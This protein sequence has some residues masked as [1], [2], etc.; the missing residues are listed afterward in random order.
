VGNYPDVPQGSR[1]FVRAATGAMTGINASGAIVFYGSSSSI[2]EAGGAIWYGEGNVPNPLL[3]C[4]CSG[5]A[6][7]GATGMFP[8][9]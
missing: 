9:A 4:D 5:L 3:N 7:P 6:V 2:D 8:Q 1:V